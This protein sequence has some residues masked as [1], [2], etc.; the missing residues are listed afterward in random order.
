MTVYRQHEQPGC[1][2]CLLLFILMLLVVGGLPLVFQVLG[3]LL[4]A[5]L[6][7]LLIT[8]VAFVAFSY[9]VKRQISAYEQSQTRTHNLFVTLLVHI[10]VKIA[11]LDNQ[12]TREEVAIIKNFFRTHLRYNHAQMLWVK[13]IIKEA[14]Q[15]ERGLDE[16]LAE[17]KQQFAYEPRLILLELVYQVL[18]TKVAVS[19]DELA[20]ADRIAVYLEIASYDQLAIKN[21]YVHRQRQAVEDELRYFD[22]LGLAP[23]ASFAEIKAAYRQLSQQYH[24]DKVSHLGEE[25]RQVAEEKMKELNIAYQYLKKKYGG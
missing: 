13:E 16:L 14:R 4:F 17:F 3:G 11:A 2:G 25:F 12:V 1:G 10:L 5:G 9:Y 21:R 22:T 20:L 19:A 8:A 23:G 15:S 7:L 18:F 6:F 24:P